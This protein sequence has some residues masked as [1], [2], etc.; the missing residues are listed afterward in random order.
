[1]LSCVSRGM[2]MV[3]SFSDCQYCWFSHDFIK[4]QKLSIVDPPKF[5]ISARESACFRKVVERQK[6]NILTN[7]HFIKGLLCW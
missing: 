3:S 7:S 1:M 5:L 6:T 4:I 2:I